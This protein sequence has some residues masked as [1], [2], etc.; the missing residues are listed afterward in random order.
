MNHK[1]H[2]FLLALFLI[3]VKSSD[4]MDNK[5]VTE[6]SRQIWT[7]PV[8]NCCDA[9]KNCAQGELCYPQ[10]VSKLIDPYDP[11]DPFSR[12]ASICGRY[13]G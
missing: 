2:S 6:S 12:S 9:S 1:L 7:P 3:E 5:F 11:F 4:W 8:P 10:D 13:E